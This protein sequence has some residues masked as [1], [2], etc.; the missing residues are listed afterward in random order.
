MWVYIGW[1]IIISDMQWP[2][3]DGFHI[4]LQSE[5]STLKTIFTWWWL[6]W[7]NI[8][9]YL[10]I[11]NLWYRSAYNWAV[12]SWLAWFWT[13]SSWWSYYWYVCEFNA[14]WMRPTDTDSRTSWHPI[15]PFKNTAVIPDSSWTVIYQWVW[16]SWIYHNSTMWLISISSD[17]TTWYTISDK[18]LWAT[19]VWSSWTPTA[20][21]WWWYYQRWNNYM[22]PF[23]WGVTTSSTKVN[24]ST[25]WPWNYY[26]SSTFITWQNADRS[27]PSNDNLRW[28]VSQW[29]TT[30][31]TELKNAYIG[32]VWTPWANTLLYLPLESDVVDKSWKS[33]R[34]FG[35]N[36]LTY[37]TVGWVQSVHVGTSW[38]ILLT[39][40]KPIVTPSVSKQTISIL[41]YVTSQQTSARR[42]ILEWRVQN[43]VWTVLAFEWGTTEIRAFWDSVGDTVSANIIANQRMHI[44]LTNCSEWKKLYLNWQLVST[45]AWVSSPRWSWA[46]SYTQNQ[47]IFTR[48]DGDYWWWLSMNGNARELI[49][50]DTIWSAEDVSNYYQRIKAKLWF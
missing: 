35:T 10:K 39:A 13:S 45:W 30:K 33:W 22:F 29:A 19:E 20:S 5:C 43:N 46:Y 27:S 12:N 28:W 42:I 40:P 17:W 44:V 34:T 21:N 37:T 1:P 24:T 49:A 2:C 47:W 8:I 6:S 50:E 14:N 4:P 41:T 25:Y 11:P 38:W 3:L 26:S 18:N 7:T 16:S 23:S 31:N 36:S 9:N 32:E 15:R 48:R